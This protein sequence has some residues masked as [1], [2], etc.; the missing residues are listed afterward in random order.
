MY[1]FGQFCM[2]FSVLIEFFFDFSVLDDF[3]LLFYGF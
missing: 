3:F 1:R 2:Q